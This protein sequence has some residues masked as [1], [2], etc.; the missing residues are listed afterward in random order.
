M[1]VIMILNKYFTFSTGKIFKYFCA[2]I[3]K[4]LFIQVLFLNDNEFFKY[5]AKCYIIFPHSI[6]SQ[7]RI[8]T[9]MKMKMKKKT[10]HQ[11][12]ILTM[13]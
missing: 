6:R 3:E 9:K 12:L 8:M 7:T 10:F 5:N 1:V 4:M 11:C 2:R 13:W